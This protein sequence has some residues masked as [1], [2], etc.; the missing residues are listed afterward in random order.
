[1][2][3]KRE[4]ESRNAKEIERMNKTKVQEKHYEARG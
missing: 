4:G 1:M 2:G 3:H